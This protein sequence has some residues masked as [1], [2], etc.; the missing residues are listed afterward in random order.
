MLSYL[1]SGVEEIYRCPLCDQEESQTN[2]KHAI[3]DD[4]QQKNEGT[5]KYDEPPEVQHIRP[6]QGI[7]EIP[8][9][10]HAQEIVHMLT[11]LLSGVEEIYRCPLCDEEESQADKKDAILDDEQQRNEGTE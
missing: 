11:Y 2:K 1:L 6:G 10:G 5:E 3:L 8:I 4:E 7:G 9:I